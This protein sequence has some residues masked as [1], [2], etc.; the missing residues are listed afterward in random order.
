MKFI[1]DAIIVLSFIFF[2]FEALIYCGDWL[3]YRKIIAEN[4][5]QQNKEAIAAIKIKK[6]EIEN[7]INDL[8]MEKIRKNEYLHELV[9][10]ENIII[11]S[12]PKIVYLCDLLSMIGCADADIIKLIINKS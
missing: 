5:Y 6:A 11:K 12:R 3:S 8:R 1:I 4:G 2:S 9:K 7:E 10:K